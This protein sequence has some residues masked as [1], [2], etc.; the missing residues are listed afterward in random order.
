M[1]LRNAKGFCTTVHAVVWRFARVGAYN[2]EIEVQIYAKGRD[3]LLPG[4]T[5]QEIDCRPGGGAI[6]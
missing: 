2:A 4:L 1:D 6:K 5:G 3:P